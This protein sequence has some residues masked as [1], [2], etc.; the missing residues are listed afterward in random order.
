[1]IQSEKLAPPVRRNA[2]TLDRKIV[3]FGLFVDFNLSSRP[4]KIEAVQ[5]QQEVVNVLKHCV[6]NNTLPN[7]LFHGPPGTGKT[8]LILAAARQLFRDQYAHRVLELNASDER[9]IRV[10]REKVKLFSQ[11]IVSGKDYPPFKLIILDEVDNI[12]TAA[13]AALRRIIEKECAHT[14]F[15]LICN[16]LSKII[17]PILSRCSKF[18]FKPLD[19]EISIGFLK[20]ILKSE[21][22]EG[23]IDEKQLKFITN[24]CNGDLRRAV[25]MLQNLASISKLG[26]RISD[27]EVASLLGSIDPEFIEEIIETIINGNSESVEKLCQK[28]YRNGLS[29]E[30]IIEKVTE[31][32]MN[33]QRYFQS[34]DC[35]KKT[36]SILCLARGEYL[37]ATGADHL[38]VLSSIL[39]KLNSLM[40]R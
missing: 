19:P 24:E 17:A 6:Q 9:G 32:L 26:K 39:L 12:T 3:I 4:N 30:N 29:V 5:Q 13:Q 1:S 25:N 11:Y 8:S 21:K 2:C 31:K 23:L 22:V 33:S 7:L 36:E 38:I 10:I 18:R 37:V 28:I 16:H 14:R 27:E 34:M 15:C 20:N 35:T 40:N